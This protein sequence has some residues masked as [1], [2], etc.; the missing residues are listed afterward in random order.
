MNKPELEEKIAELDEKAER[1]KSEIIDG[2][3]F[4]KT[5]LEPKNIA[6]SAVFSVVTKV[7]SVFNFRRKQG[8]EV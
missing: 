2:F 7:R 8:R 5:S 1:G 3:H 6:K 4:L